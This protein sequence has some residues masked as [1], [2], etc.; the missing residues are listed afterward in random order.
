S[1]ANQAAAFDR[2]SR[3]IFNCRFSRRNCA[4]SWRSAVVNPPSP[5]PA[6]RSACCNQRVIAQIEQPNSRANSDFFRPA[7][8]NSTICRWN[9][10]GYR[11]AF[12][13]VDLD[14]DLI[15]TDSS[16]VHFEESTKP[17][18]LQFV[19]SVRDAIH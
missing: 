9:S 17:G 18:Q 6:S 16:H 14:F 2:M 5:R 11:F 19:V 8:T 3:S 13:D 15:M 4:N 10:G 7:R 12:G 1:W